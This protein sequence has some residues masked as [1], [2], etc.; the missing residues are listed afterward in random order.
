M[1]PQR[2]LIS[3]DGSRPPCTLTG[4]DVL[5]ARNKRVAGIQCVAVREH[6]LINHVDPHRPETI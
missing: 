1:K 6:D 4:I 3:Q 5:H 2:V